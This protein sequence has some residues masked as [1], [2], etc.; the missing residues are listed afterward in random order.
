MRRKLPAKRQKVFGKWNEAVSGN[1]GNA[2]LDKFS[3]LR[4]VSVSVSEERLG[5]L[6]PRLG[7]RSI[8]RQTSG[9]AT[10][11]SESGKQWEMFDSQVTGSML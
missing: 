8:S 7:F 11:H 1:S 5:H 3:E 2:G 10:I 6:A 4:G 9:M